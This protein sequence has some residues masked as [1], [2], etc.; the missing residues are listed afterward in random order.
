[1]D[2]ARH[3]TPPLTTVQ[4]DYRALGANAVQ[5]LLSLVANPRA[6][7]HQRIIFPK[8]IVRESTAPPA[9]R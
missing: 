6:A 8:L 1:M 9:E 5:H 7:A 3:C 2:F 4:Q